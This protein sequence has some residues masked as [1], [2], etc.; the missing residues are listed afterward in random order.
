MEG[1]ERDIRQGRLKDMKGK[2]TVPTQS[3]PRANLPTKKCGVSQEKLIL[4]GGFEELPAAC[5]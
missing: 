4:K 5:Y 3:D 1:R 2:N